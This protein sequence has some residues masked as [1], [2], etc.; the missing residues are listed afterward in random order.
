MVGFKEIVSFAKISNKP[1]FKILWKLFLLVP[2][3]EK[4]RV[5]MG[6][7]CYYG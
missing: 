1:I 7:G 2:E 6:G 3:M 5:M 4:F